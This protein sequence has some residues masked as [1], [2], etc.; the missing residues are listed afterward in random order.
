MIQAETPQARFSASPAGSEKEPLAGVTPIENILSLPTGQSEAVFAEA[1]QTAMGTESVST[2]QPFEMPPVW[3][4]RSGVPEGSF[5]EADRFPAGLFGLQLGRR[6]GSSRVRLQP[7]AWTR[8]RAAPPTRNPT[9]ATI[10]PGDMVSAVL[11]E[12]DLS[13]NASCTVTAIVDGRVYV[14]GHPLFGFGPVQ[15]PMARGRVLTTLSSDLEST[16][17]VNVGGISGH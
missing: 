1:P 17:I 9:I 5:L 12:G 14:C 2:M 4:S 7:T 8:R 16:K 6:S 11:L 10:K 3:T 15:I 13:M